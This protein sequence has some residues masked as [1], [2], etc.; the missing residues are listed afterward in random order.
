MHVYLFHLDVAFG[1][2]KAYAALCREIAE[3]YIG[4]TI[5]E[6]IETFNKVFFRKLVYFQLALHHK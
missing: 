5:D 4:C 6:Y 1:S 3:I 2:H